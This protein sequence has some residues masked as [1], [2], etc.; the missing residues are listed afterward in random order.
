MSYPHFGEDRTIAGRMRA[1]FF[2]LIAEKTSF[3][4]NFDD[5]DWKTIP[6]HIARKMLRSNS[7]PGFTTVI[8]SENDGIFVV[9][10]AHLV[11]FDKNNDILCSKLE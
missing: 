5:I 8:D 9:K 2:E 4:I 10:R 3:T 1:I 11:D 7:V 6:S